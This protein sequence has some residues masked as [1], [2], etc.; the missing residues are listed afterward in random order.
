MSAVGAAATEQAGDPD[1]PAA[2]AS[3]SVPPRTTPS[4]STSIQTSPLA[5]VSLSA[6]TVLA[7]LPFGVAAR[8]F[9]AFVGAAFASIADVSPHALA[10]ARSS[11]GDGVAT[12]A[13][14]A[15]GAG[16]GASLRLRRSRSAK[17]GAAGLPATGAWSAGVGAASVVTGATSAAVVPAPVLRCG[18]GLNGA[19]LTDVPAGPAR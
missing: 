13:A 1:A 6:T 9:A 11:A 18:P 2:D 16:A 19:M 4:P 14:G 8:A 3:P 10:S 12:G 15:A 5:F 17:R 7:A